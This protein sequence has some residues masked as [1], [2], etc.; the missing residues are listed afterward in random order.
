MID[1]EWIKFASTGS[2]QAYLDYRDSLRADGL[3]G[4]KAPSG[5]EAR[6][7]AGGSVKWNGAE[8][9][10]D[11]HGAVGGPDRGI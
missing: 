2:I 7:D 8:H 6:E 10:A 5:E 1:R 3:Y 9:T 4:G 11:R